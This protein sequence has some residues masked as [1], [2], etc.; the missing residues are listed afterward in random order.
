MRAGEFT[1]D[2]FL[3]SYRMLRRMGPVKGVL[4]LV[5]GVGSS[6]TGSTSTRSR[7]RASRRSCSR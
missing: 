6:S 3:Q 4:K 2:D 7:W 1:F 5:P